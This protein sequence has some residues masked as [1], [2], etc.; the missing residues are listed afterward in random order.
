LPIRFER[1]KTEMEC[2]LAI[3]TGLPLL[4]VNIIGWR[5]ASLYWRPRFPEVVEP[6]A[7]IAVILPLRGADASL[8]GCLRSLLAQDH[9][10]YELHIV[11]DHPSDPAV[12]IVDSVLAERTSDHPMVH[13]SHLRRALPTC[14]LKVSAQLQA[15]EELASDVHLLA[16]IDADADPP[17]NWLRLLAAPF[18]DP[19]ILA[20]T[21]VR[22]YAPRD[23]QWGSLVRHLWNCGSQPYMHQF[24][25]V[26]GGTLALRTSLFHEEGNRDHFRKCLF[27]DTA[28]ANLV[29]RHRG[30]IRW[31]PELTTINCESTTLAECG[32]FVRR[33]LLGPFVDLDNRRRLI[34]F[35]LAVAFALVGVIVMIPIEAVLGNWTWALTFA[36]IAAVHLIGQL[37]PLALVERRIRRIVAERG[38]T[39]PPAVQHWKSHVAP[40]VTEAMHLYCMLR[41]VLAESVA[42][43]GVFY[44]IGGHEDI[45]L[46]RYVPFGTVLPGTKSAMPR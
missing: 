7:K 38:Q 9:P 11:I 1:R 43:R 23:A 5:F 28:A 41:A 8:A 34:A 45:R 20:A 31:L 36:S 42:W 30:R 26:W 18:R 22:W 29:R 40:L 12:A 13:V 44:R 16:F 10:N 35:N 19:S 37:I 27:D 21:G 3:F 39:A 4:T 33:Q 2:C 6:A 25:L 24:G 15:I 17:R 32:T 46:V 14:S